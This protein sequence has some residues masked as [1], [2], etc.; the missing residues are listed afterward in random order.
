MSLVSIIMPAY[1]A[2]EFIAEAIESVLLQTYPEWELIII[3]DGS[4]DKTL[5]IAQSFAGKESRIKLIAQTNQ[6]VSVARNNGIQ[7]AKGTYITF[8]DADDFYLPR[9][10]QKMTSELESSN[11]DLIQCGY[12][13]ERVAMTISYP[14]T[15][16]NLLEIWALHKYFMVY[17]SAFM[18]KHD[19]L[20]Q[21]HL[22]F[23]QQQKMSEDFAFIVKCA[24]YGK[25]KII[26]DILTFY[27]HNQASVS[28]DINGAKA[29]NDVN[30]RQAIL[31]FVK[32]HYH[33]SHKQQV[34][35]FLEGAMHGVAYAF[36]KQVWGYIKK[37][38]YD[39]AMD[40]LKQYGA[41]EKN[42]NKKPLRYALQRTVINSQNPTLW[43]LFSFIK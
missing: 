32:Q 33:A 3:D 39:K 43:K 13:F 11:C 6:G 41:I 7:S 17:P 27:R 38:Q 24:V 20:K 37:G 12:V 31:A 22:L 19:L 10:L 36:Q 14:L 23:D 40:D 29:R 5:E 4:S 16:G 28:I 1:N 26:P 34:C 8:L 18:V 25:A 30:T 2:Q 35:Q 15:E 9:F 42:R 21:H